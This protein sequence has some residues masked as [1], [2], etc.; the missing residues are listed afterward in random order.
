MAKKV[1]FGMHW[2]MYGRQT[3][4]L[5]DDINAED[6]EAVRAYIISQWDHIPLPSGDYVMASDEL[7]VESVFIVEVVK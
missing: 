3:I 1:S 7:D 6:D 5:P 4:E 2:E